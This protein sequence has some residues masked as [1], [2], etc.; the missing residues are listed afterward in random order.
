MLKK[1]KNEINTIKW[2]NKKVILQDMKIVTL[3]S[4]ALM[5]VMTGIEFGAKY[6]LSII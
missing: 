4:V 5:L 6:I 2:P 1:I 3:C